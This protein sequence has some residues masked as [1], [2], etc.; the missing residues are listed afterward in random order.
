MRALLFLATAFV[1]ALA[2]TTESSRLDAI[3]N[4]I[5]A[6]RSTLSL[7]ARARV[8]TTR[9]HAVLRDRADIIGQLVKTGNDSDLLLALEASRRFG[10]SLRSFVS[11]IVGADV[12]TQLLEQR[13]YARGPR[14]T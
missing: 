5:K 14:C 8:D 6:L 9:A 12:S 13:E 10:P 7:S 4:E 11:S 2:H 1:C 3:F